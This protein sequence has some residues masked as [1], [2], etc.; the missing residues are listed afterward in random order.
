MSEQDAAS[1]SS[2][3]TTLGVGGL[4][5]PDK[6]G[7]PV[8][9]TV[10][11]HQTT[12]IDVLDM[13][14]AQGTA[15]E[16]DA[17]D[18]KNEASTSEAHA[19]EAPDAEAM[20][21]APVFSG[22]IMSLSAGEQNDDRLDG[23]LKFQ[24]PDQDLPD[25]RRFSA[26]AAAVALAALTGALGGALATAAI[27]HFA[28][29]DVARTENGALQASVARIEADILA[30]ASSVEHT[31]K[32]GIAQFNKASDRLDKLEKAQAEPAARIAKLSETVDKLRATTPA[33][34]ATQ[35]AA[36]PQEITGSIAP[37]RTT[38]VPPKLEVAKLPRI[39]GWILRDVAHGSAL[40][41][42]RRGYY[43]VYAGDAVPGLGRVDAIKR[44]NG[45]WVVVTSRGLV[46]AR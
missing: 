29:D 19:M 34:A 31:S 39:E 22:K 41:E 32:A 35:V 15:P 18:A 24:Q 17:K 4:P 13:V 1:T 44:Q 23:D 40:I 27:S 14:A 43:V 28:G 6:H 12:E 21:D 26:L 2:E 16:A 8:A 5:S 38:P 10:H 36:A 33:P 42:G 30:L 9:T 46:E 45:R 3:S 20:S 37:A 7:E 25:K 11:V